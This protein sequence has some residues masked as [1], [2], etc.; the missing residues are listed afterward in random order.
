MKIYN[1][2]VSLFHYEF[3]F[4]QTTNPAFTLR[5]SRTRRRYNDFCWL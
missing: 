4:L 5:Q 3:L 1:F 2:T